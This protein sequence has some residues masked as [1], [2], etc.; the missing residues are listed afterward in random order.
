M[1][2]LGPWSVMALISQRGISLISSLIALFVVSMGSLAFISMRVGQEKEALALKQKLANIHL[3]S[4]ITEVFYNGF[5]SCHFDASIN[6]ITP[7]GSLLLDTA[8]LSNINLGVIRPNCVFKSSKTDL[9]KSNT[10]L[11][12]GGGLVVKDIMVKDLMSIGSR[13][14]V[15]EYSGNLVISYKESSQVRL[16]E[17]ISI[18]LIFSVD[19]TSKAFSTKKPIQYCWEEGV[20]YDDGPEC[21]QLGEDNAILHSERT[22]LLGCGVTIKST[23]KEK[24][25]LGFDVAAQN[26]GSQGKTNVSVGTYLGFQSGNQTPRDR[27]GTQEK[28]TFLGFKSG[29]K[30]TDSDLTMIGYHSTPPHGGDISKFVW[31]GVDIGKGKNDKKDG[32]NSYG[33][34]IGSHAGEVPNTHAIFVG[35]EAGRNANSGI[36]L[37]DQAGLHAAN[38]GSGYHEE[39]IFIGTRAGLNRRIRGTSRGLLRTN[40]VIIGHEA[41]V[42]VGTIR[43]WKDKIYLLAKGVNKGDPVVMAGDRILIGQGAGQ[44]GG[45]LGLMIGFEAG[46][47]DFSGLNS[48]DYETY[49]RDGVERN[50][51]V[52]MSFLIFKDESKNDH[53]INLSNTVRAYG[54]NFFV[55]GQ[56]GSN[57]IRGMMNTFLGFQSG[58]SKLGGDSNTYIGA[59]AGYSDG[60]DSHSHNNTCIGWKSC[61]ANQGSVTMPFSLPSGI[62]VVAWRQDEESIRTGS[63]NTILGALAGKANIHGS[64]NILIGKGVGSSAMYSDINNKFMVGTENNQEW[65]SG[66][67]NATSTLSVNGAALTTPSSRA[68]KKNIVPVKNFKKY[69]QSILETPLF[70]YQYKELNLH[71]DKV[72]MGVIS[73]ELPK[74]LQ[75][76]QKGRLSRPD[77]PSI[78]GVFAASIK[79][80]Y[81]STMTLEKTM[82]TKLN[83]FM[84]SL[85]QLERG[86]KNMK[87]DVDRW[88][89][90]INV[91]KN[92]I[93][94]SKKVIKEMR[95]EISKTKSYTQRKWEELI[96]DDPREDKGES[97]E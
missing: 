38:H 77:W 61:Y 40:D 21:L 82:L 66:D 63:K 97:H 50:V 8:Q 55:G 74:Y 15:N 35:T 81:E 2:D 70:T 7:S 22:S 12:N 31:I 54:A 89:K 83:E 19:P 59:F 13:G 10:R 92:H 23:K 24:T 78:Y 5:C 88:M 6:R 1:N 48:F 25:A 67:I 93:K 73:E 80:I 18:P 62:K 56:S 39:Q 76:K 71:P 94:Q 52:S 26:W 90:T 17:P 84:N 44:A 53:T 60:T 45:G 46:Q 14:S 95:G 43:L 36:I 57:F 33:V 85:D 42:N 86:Y 11:R 41:G 29:D 3:E 75:I 47:K 49:M 20:H 79:W 87:K 96:G 16:L 4:S 34:V 28:N 51:V 32:L 65:L 58:Y 30:I 37:G 69:L 68:L 72:R 64:H 9:V 91:T 27:E